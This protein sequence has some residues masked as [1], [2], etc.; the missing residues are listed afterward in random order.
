MT[1]RL[2]KT[3]G[4]QANNGY[5]SET[6]LKHFRKDEAYQGKEIG[7]KRDI[8]ILVTGLKLL[9]FDS[10]DCNYAGISN[11]GYILVTGLKPCRYDIGGC[12]TY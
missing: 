12:T 11:N 4:L 7:K 3:P 2:R 9:R 8:T 1:I 10:P 6:G 5:I